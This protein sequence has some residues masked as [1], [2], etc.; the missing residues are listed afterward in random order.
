MY[1]KRNFFEGKRRGSRNP[2]DR[3]EVE[4]RGGKE[5]GRGALLLTISGIITSPIVRKAREF[6]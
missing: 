3:N 2:K 5:R 4:K 6:S 1:Q